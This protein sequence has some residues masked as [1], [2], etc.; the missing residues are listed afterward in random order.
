MFHLLPKT[1]SPVAFPSPGRPAPRPHSLLTFSSPEISPMPSPH[2]KDKR[3]SVPG[4]LNPSVYDSP[5]SPASS[6]SLES[7]RRRLRRQ[8]KAVTLDLSGFD[9]SSEPES[10]P[11][12]VWRSVKRTA[13]LKEERP[14][15]LSP[16]LKQRTKSSKVKASQSFRGLLR[17]HKE[18]A[19]EQRSSKEMDVVVFL[20]GDLFKDGEFEVCLQCTSQLVIIWSISRLFPTD[21]PTGSPLHALCGSHL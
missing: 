4:N 17:R 5:E 19:E 10:G 2:P 7:R 1:W 13:S 21:S 6:G 3:R 15:R 9:H 16:K 11:S 14:S 18:W 8:K 12:S 20:S